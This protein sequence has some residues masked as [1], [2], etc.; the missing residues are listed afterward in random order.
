MD[1]SKLIVPLSALCFSSNEHP[2]KPP[3]R[4]KTKHIAKIEKSYITSDIIRE[5]KIAIYLNGQKLLSIIA[6]PKESDAHVVGFLKSEGVIE[7]RE[8]IKSI[9]INDDNT[10]VF[11]E[12]S[13]KECN[14]ANLFH[15]KTLTSGCCVGIAGNDGGLI[16]DFN[17]ASFSLYASYIFEA[18][19]GFEANSEL[20]HKTGC[21]HKA[22]LIYE[23]SK[24]LCE[25]Q[26]D[27]VQSNLVE[28]KTH[29]T[30]NEEC[31]AKKRSLKTLEA[32]D[33]GR[34][35][36]IDKVLGLALLSG[37]NTRRAALMVSGRLSQEMIIKAAM[38]SIPIVISRAA[39]TFLGI[40]SAQD[41]GITLVGFAREGRLLVYTHEARIK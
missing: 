28:S 24:D 1:T 26:K 11:I 41:L 6:L 32:Q 12:A 38:S 9:V 8:D 30:P 39:T 4:G 10:E 21:A 35:N 13:I 31:L 2:S 37:I 18:L 34:H 36:A 23:D 33:I 17:D 14:L 29:S 5:E 27:L 19:R 22:M 40:K 16:K 20:F 15:E 3:N 25:G 7:R